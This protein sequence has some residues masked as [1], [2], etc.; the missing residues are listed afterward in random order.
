VSDPSADSRYFSPVIDYLSRQPVLGR[1]EIPFTSAH[2]EAAYVA[3]RIPL[4]RGWLRQLDVRDD[5]IFYASKRLNPMTYRQWLIRNG[6]TW[7]ALPDVALDYSA[8][9]EA[10]FLKR[11]LPYLHL[12]WRDQHWIVWKVTDS[13]GLVSGP[14]RLT[15]LGPDHVALDAS[16]A[17]TVLVRVH[18]TSTWAVTSGDA[19]VLNRNGWTEVVVRR[20]GQ[21][22][23]TTSLLPTSNGCT[24]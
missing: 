9:R 24:G 18:Y 15:A 10:N 7:I 13:P 20:P 2:W 5:P 4:A 8:V 6:V 17:G 14:A 21:I 22:D 23:L 16:V 12:V 3:P 11:G 19:C 1:V